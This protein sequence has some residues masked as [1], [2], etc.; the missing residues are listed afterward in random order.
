MAENSV[1]F[2]HR[3]TQSWRFLLRFYGHSL[4]ASAAYLILWG[5]LS[6]VGIVLAAGSASEGAWGMAAACAA[7]ALLCLLRGFLLGLIRLR[8]DF[9]KTAAE[10][11]K[12][13]WE[14]VMRFDDTGIRME[15]NGRPTAEVAWSDIQKLEERGAWLRLTFR[16]VAELYLRKGDFTSGTAAEFQTWLKA[17][18]PEIVQTKKN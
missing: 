11:G 15:D 3:H 16:G 5:G 14:S 12:D 8:R 17:E 2:E 13:S 18:H 4:T 9:K 10:Y 6:A 1:R 7:V